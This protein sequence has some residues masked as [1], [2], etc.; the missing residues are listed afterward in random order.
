MERR[1]LTP[2][3]NTHLAKPSNMLRRCIRPELN[4][5]LG[6]R[7]SELSGR[8][9]NLPRATRSPPPP[10]PTQIYQISS[11]CSAQGLKLHPPCLPYPCHH[12]TCSTGH[13][14]E[15]EVRGLFKGQNTRKA[16]GP[17]T[18]S[19]AALKH[20][21]SE[22]A[23]VFTDIFNQSLNVCRVPVCF[24]SAVIIPVPKK[25]KITCLND[26]RPVALTSVVMKT[27][28]RLVLSYLKAST[29]HLMDPQF[30]YRANRSVDINI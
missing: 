28:E 17:D 13:H 6:I 14:R 24:K 2:K 15:H 21:A 10:L 1:T 9:Y 11:M 4:N 29:D 5:R 3:P 27:F 16:W 12:L 20:C 18:V 19:P 26:Y 30:A 23:P 25:P 8:A 22:L 7:T